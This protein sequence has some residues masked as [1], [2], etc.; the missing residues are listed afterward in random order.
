MV[1]HLALVHLQILLN[2]FM[3]QFLDEPL[4]AF[5]FTLVLNV[6]LLQLLSHMQDL[7]QKQW[8]FTCLL[9]HLN[10]YNR[11]LLGCITR[12]LA[13]DTVNLLLKVNQILLVLSNFIVNSLHLFVLNITYFHLMATYKLLHIL[14]SNTFL[15]AKQL[16]H[17]SHIRELYPYLTL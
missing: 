11:D 7:S 14:R 9:L 10:L 16:V 2:H 17:I 4:V 3:I 12:Q 15:L 5:L 13:H 6:H 8:I 1:L